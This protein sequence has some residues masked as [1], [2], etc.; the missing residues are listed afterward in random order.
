MPRRKE[1]NNKNLKETYRK[2]AFYQRKDK[3]ENAN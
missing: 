1:I 2:T 3:H